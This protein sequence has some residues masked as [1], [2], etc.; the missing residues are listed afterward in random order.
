MLLRE[1]FE[2]TKKTAVLAF[3]RLNPPT[4]GHAKLVNTIESFDGDHYLFL[5]QSQK[6]KTDPLDFPT[7]L[8]FAK[9]FFINNAKG[10]NPM[11]TVVRPIVENFMNYSFFRDAPIVP[12]SLDKNLPNKFYTYDEKSKKN[13]ISKNYIK[14]ERVKHQIKD[15]ITF[16]RITCASCYD[17]GRN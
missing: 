9:Q 11:P 16:I 13:I 3:G 17:I 12:K 6:P 2:Q 10:F 7:K 14:K 8:K 15:K 4:V 5:S 1:L